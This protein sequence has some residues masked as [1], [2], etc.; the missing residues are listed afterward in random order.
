MFILIVI[1]LSFAL[2]NALVALFLDLIL[3]SLKAVTQVWHNTS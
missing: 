1:N 3:S 2:T